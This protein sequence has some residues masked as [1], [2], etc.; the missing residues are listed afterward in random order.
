MDFRDSFRL[1]VK[2]FPD[3]DCIVFEDKRFTYSEAKERIDRLAQGLRNLGIRQGDRIGILQVNCHQFVETIYAST[4]IGAIIVPINFR[5]K[6]EE[7]EYIVSQAEMSALVIGGRYLEIIQSLHPKIPCVREYISLD[8]P[9]PGMIFYE[10]L[11]KSSANQEVVERV[12]DKD[13]VIILYTSGTTGLPKG[14]MLSYRAIHHLGLSMIINLKLDYKDVVMGGGPLYHMGTFGYLIPSFYVGATW[15]MVRQFDVQEVLKVIQ[16]EKI[17]V[18]WFAPS[19]INFMLQFPQIK[20]YDLSSLRLIQYGGSPMPPQVLKRAI[21]VLRC[22]FSQIYGLTEA[23][24]QT[25]LEPEDHFYEGPEEKVKLLTSIGRPAPNVEVRIVNNKDEHVPLGSVGEIIC[26]CDT[27]ME[28]YWRKPKESRE[29][30]RQKWLHTGDL[31]RKDKDG[32]IYLVDRK[33]DMI[34]RGGENIYP[35][36]IEKVLYEYPKVMEAAV[37][38]VPDETWGESVKAVVVLKKG[39]QATEEEIIQYCRERLASYK[40]PT[41]VDF[42]ENLPRTS[43]GKVLKTDL[44]SK[45]WA[46]QSRKI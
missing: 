22:K 29:A 14:A 44:R 6:A 33:K 45:F 26:R 43:G 32:Y 41:S 18:C 8:Q 35:V 39:A 4:Q 40:K 27:M 21:E 5:L 2:K 24:P 17:T 36:E 9:E 37:I 25:F 30:L 28:G 19:M 23:V 46:G 1:S 11:I 34:I 12:K 15:V 3:K 16:N 10:E 42:V 7:I 31:A 38:G 20:D 13:T